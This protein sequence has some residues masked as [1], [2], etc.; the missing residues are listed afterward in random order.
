MAASGAALIEQEDVVA[1]R[2]EQRPV[3]VL[4]SA[5]RPAVQEHD[6][7]AALGSDFLDVD[8]MPI[9]DIDHAGVEGAERVRQGLHFR[10]EQH[11]VRFAK[12]LNGR[13]CR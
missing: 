13:G 6:G 8:P 11:C 3:H 4:R 7:P 5:A 2:V 9:A 1:R 12:A 10:F